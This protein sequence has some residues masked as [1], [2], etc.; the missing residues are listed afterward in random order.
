[1]STSRPRLRRPEHL[2]EIDRLAHAVVEEAATEGWLTFDPAEDQGQTALQRS[3][4][5]LARALQF[6]HDE[7]DGCSDH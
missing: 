3:I 2:E 5:E 7:V 6:V 1:V 4:N